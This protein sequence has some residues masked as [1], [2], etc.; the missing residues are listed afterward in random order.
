MALGLKGLLAGFLSAPYVVQRLGDFD[1]GLEFKTAMVYADASIRQQ[2]PNTKPSPVEISGNFPEGEGAAAAAAAVV[3]G[4][5]EEAGTAVGVELSGIEASAVRAG[6]EGGVGGGGAALGEC[7]VVLGDRDV[8]ETLRRR[9]GALTAL[10]DR[11]GKGEEGKGSKGERD[12]IGG[13]PGGRGGGGEGVGGG[14]RGAAGVG[15]ASVAGGV[16][17]LG[18]GGIGELEVEV[19]GRA[20]GKDTGGWVRRLMG[21]LREVRGWV[22]G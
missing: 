10:T 12:G 6:V 1:P 18:T 2:S 11:S 16:G 20:R 22:G 7:A 21:G 17:V 8:Q 14:Q 13:S 19:S 3:A 5:G 15:V 4:G 9:G